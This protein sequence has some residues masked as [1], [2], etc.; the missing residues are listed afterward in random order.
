MIDFEFD[1]EEDVNRAGVGHMSLRQAVREIMATPAEER[2][3]VML[4]R[5]SG[6]EPSCL[7]A[8]QIEELAALPQ[9]Q[10]HG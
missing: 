3:F 10:G 7:E 9:F 1:P 8:E 2:G 4:Y 6:K 5:E